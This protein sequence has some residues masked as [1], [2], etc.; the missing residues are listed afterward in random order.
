MVTV[1][2]VEVVLVIVAV[3]MRQAGACPSL[4]LRDREQTIISVPEGYRR[5]GE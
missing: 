3:R 1:R 2:A 4:R 5:R